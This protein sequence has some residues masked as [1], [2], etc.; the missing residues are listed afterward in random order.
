MVDQALLHRRMLRAY[1]V[2]RLRMALRIL[3]WLLPL[4]IVCLTISHRPLVCAAV[5]TALAVAAVALRWRDRAGVAQVKLGLLTG[6]VPLA[7]ALG[8]GQLEA[9]TGRGL[10]C[11]PI[12]V[13]SAAIAGLWL[14]MRVAEQRRHV[15]A[16]F[17]VI[18]IAS[19]TASLGCLNLGLSGMLGIA[20]GI[21][22]ASSVS[23]A[24]CRVT[25]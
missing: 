11:T 6:L 16:W 18:V 9:L 23:V 19:T 2:G 17:T 20:L 8:V 12:C 22:L 24:W 21:A 1:E 15:R 3:V 13:V 10:G 4:T 7:V 25:P 5:A 14:G